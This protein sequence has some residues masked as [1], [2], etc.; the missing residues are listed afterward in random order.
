MTSFRGT[1]EPAWS[2]AGGRKIWSDQNVAW[3]MRSLIDRNPR[4]RAVIKSGPVQRTLHGIRGSQ[5]VRERASFMG[6]QLRGRGVA[7][8]RLHN[9]L[10]VS[11]RHGTPD[12][13]IFTRVFWRRIYDPPV[14]L[15]E[16]LRRPLRVLDLGANIGL[17][18][19]SLGPEATVT[20][21][22]ADH[23]NAVLL[24]E[25]VTANGLPWNVIN[26]YAGAQNG[27]I[28]FIGGQHCFSRADE[29]GEPLKKID[30]FPLFEGVDLLKMDIEGG[31]WEILHDPRMADLGPS[32]VVIEWHIESCPDANPASAARAAL[33]AAGYAHIAVPN[34]P[35]GPPAEFRECG[36][37][38][39]WR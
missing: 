20:A 35:G 1:G 7:S 19:A 26:A 2:P 25:M 14:E 33:R 17:F 5:A 8:Y 34:E 32:V 28:R 11:V 15:R 6:R 23:N 9:G 21:V 38:W 18:S 31:E 24:E 13:S 4:V 37:L 27:A 12:M 29:S 10:R 16:R 22:E 39:A 36:H 3:A 30:V